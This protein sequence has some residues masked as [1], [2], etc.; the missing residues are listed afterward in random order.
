MAKKKVSKRPKK[1]DK[2]L[3]LKEGLELDD[4]IG[5][6]LK[7]QPKQAPKSKPAKGKKKK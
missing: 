3:Q 5:L 2:P 1:Y 6:A 7:T 4:L